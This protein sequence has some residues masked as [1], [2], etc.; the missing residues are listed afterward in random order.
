[1]GGFNSTTVDQLPQRV[2]CPRQRACSG[3][4]ESCTGMARC[5][6]QLTLWGNWSTVVEL[7][8]H[9]APPASSQSAGQHVCQCMLETTTN[10]QDKTYTAPVR[11]TAMGI[12]ESSWCGHEA[13]SHAR[14]AHADAE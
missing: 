6:G 3:P 12:G 4:L 10:V 11:G 9:W 7:N 1:M 13:W 8:P 2:S 5:R 14:H